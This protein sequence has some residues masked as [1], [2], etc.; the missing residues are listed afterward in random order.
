MSYNEEVSA[1]NDIH[2][3]AYNVEVSSCYA[4]ILLYTLKVTAY[5]V[6]VIAL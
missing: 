1:C 4:K 3:S 6:K 2:V 5:N